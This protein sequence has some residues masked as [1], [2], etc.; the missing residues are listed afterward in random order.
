M[1]SVQRNLYAMYTVSQNYDHDDAHYNFNADEPILV[2][3]GKDVAER[4]CYQMVICYSTSP[5]LCFCTTWGNMNMTPRKLSYQSC[6]IPCLESDTA[7]A[8]YIFDI[9]QPILIIFC[10][11]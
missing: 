5:N 9:R 10:R 1:F 7:L 2:I 11:Q 3:L 8:C 4:V 6:C